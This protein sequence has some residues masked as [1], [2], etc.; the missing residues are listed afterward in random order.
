MGM[1]DVE[2]YIQ[3]FVKKNKKVIQTNAREA[4]GGKKDL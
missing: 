4:I 3:I 1:K 2:N